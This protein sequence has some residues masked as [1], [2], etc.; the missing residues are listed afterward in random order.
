[1]ESFAVGAGIAPDLAKFYGGRIQ[2]A[3]AAPALS[4]EA[5]QQSARETHQAMIDQFGDEAPGLMEVAQ[6]E[7]RLLSRDYPDLPAILERT[8]LGND[9]HLIKSLIYR[10]A[11]REMKAR[12]HKVP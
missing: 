11:A 6:R 3:L 2:K 12:G 5:Q 8:N 9:M 4:F 1:M 7:V 10:A